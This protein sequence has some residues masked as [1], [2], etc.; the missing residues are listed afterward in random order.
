[1]LNLR[2]IEVAAAQSLNSR[3]HAGLNGKNVKTFLFIE[4]FSTE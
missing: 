1:M 2:E 3:Q 4:A